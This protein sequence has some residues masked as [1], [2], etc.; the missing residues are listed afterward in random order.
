MSQKSHKKP[1]DDKEPEKDT[2]PSLYVFDF[3]STLITDKG[4]LY[5]VQQDGARK[6]IGVSEY[7]KYN[8][9]PGESVDMSEF[10]E[11]MDPTIHE[12]IMNL[13][14]DHVDE[15]V[16]LTARNNAKPVR[17]FMN[18]I[19]V[20]VPKIVAVGITGAGVHEVR[21]NAERKTLWLDREISQRDLTYVEVWDD[22]ELNLAYIGGLR[23]KYPNTSIVTHLVNHNKVS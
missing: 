4:T 9:K 20:F 21:I 18:K 19:R 5:L 17:R 16:I 10:S 8:F 3:D 7:H 12:N 2:S 1:I 15:A 23:K 6:P 14:R 11:V 13:L 22:N